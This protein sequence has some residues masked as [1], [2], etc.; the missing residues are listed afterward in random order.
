MHERLK[1]A[2][3]AAGFYSATEAI[4]KHGWRG[5]TYR[6]HENGQNQYDTVTARAYAAAFNTTASWLLTGEEPLEAASGA[7]TLSHKKIYV[8]GRIAGGEWIE[9]KIRKANVVSV[10]IFP[11]D[12]RYPIEA[13]FDLSVHGESLNLFAQD[14]DYVRC[15][16]LLVVEE[17]I[18]DE[19]LLIIERRTEQGLTEVTARRL[20]E[21]GS[22]RF[23]SF[24]SDSP[25]F[26]DQIDLDESI[27]VTAKVLWKYRQ[28]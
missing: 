2:R 3:L 10:S 4:N 8:K 28:A 1:A 27:K 5:S 17:K 12:A 22:R 15:I 14:G 19:D 13:Q 9:E 16:D 24:E 11:P 21:E 18:K 6:A 7:S 26:Q 23:L 25:Y 20:R